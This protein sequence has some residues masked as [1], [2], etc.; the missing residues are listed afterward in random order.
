VKCLSYVSELQHGILGSQSHLQEQTVYISAKYVTEIRSKSVIFTT[1]CMMYIQ[2]GFN[3][4]KKK[5]RK[6]ETENTVLLTVIQ[7]K[8]P[9]IAKL[10]VTQE[11]STLKI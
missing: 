4:H 1:I 9:M 11:K 7:R 10:I 6:K 8:V 3:S 2:R 5:E